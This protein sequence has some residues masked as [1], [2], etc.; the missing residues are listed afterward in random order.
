MP[1]KYP[2]HKC[3]NPECNNITN[4][5]NCC[6]KDCQNKV[7]STFMKKNA[8]WK[9]GMVDITC[10]VCGIVFQEYPSHVNRRAT[11]GKQECVDTWRNRNNIVSTCVVCGKQRVLSPSMIRQTCGDPKCVHIVTRAENCHLYIHGNSHAPYPLTFNNFLREQI[12]ERDGRVCQ[13]CGLPEDQN[14]TRKGELRKLDVHHIDY[15]K[16]N[17]DESNLISLCLKCHRFTNR[18]KREYYTK[19]FSEAT[20]RP[21]LPPNI[22]NPPAIANTTTSTAPPYNTSSDD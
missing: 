6:S 12:R 13:L 14:F 22:S 19:L 15:N 4:N 5:R 8:P 10:P 17:L 7:H 21:F 20:H 9:K 1:I 18:N 16:H 11:C 3:D 2:A